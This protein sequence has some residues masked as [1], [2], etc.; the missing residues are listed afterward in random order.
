MSRHAVVASAPL[1]LAGLVSVLDDLTS[2]TGTDRQELVHLV[3]RAL[4][5]THARLHPDDPPVIARFDPASAAV[6]LTRVDAE[7]QVEVVAQEPELLRQAALAVRSG[8]TA[9]VRE[10]ERAR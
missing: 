3:E 2:T 7:G 10:A 1:Q 9:L 8:V 4:A 6:E 5:E